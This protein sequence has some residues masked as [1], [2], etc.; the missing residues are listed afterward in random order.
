MWCRDAPRWRFTSADLDIAA[1]AMDNPDYVDVVIHNYRVRQ[2]AAP[3]DPRYAGLEARL[4]ARSHRS[5][6]RR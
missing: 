5:R 4:P 3:G 6:C 2:G 1:A